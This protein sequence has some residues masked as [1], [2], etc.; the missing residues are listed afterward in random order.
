M[1]LFF[2]QSFISKQL[3]ATFQNAWGSAWGNATTPYNYI[4]TVAFFCCP[5]S[6][7]NSLPPFS[8]GMNLQICF[9]NETA[10][11]TE[12]ASH[13]G[14]RSA[15]VASGH[16]PTSPLSPDSPTSSSS[17][18]SSSGYSIASSPS[19]LQLQQ[20]HNLQQNIARP[21]VLSLPPLR[22]DSTF[23]DAPIDEADFFA[24]QA[25]LQTEARMA[26]AQAKEMAHMQMEVER[27]KLKQNPITE[28]VRES[29]S[30]VSVLFFT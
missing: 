6:H 24:R 2:I 1:R 22:L 21:Q 29:L 20:L 8:A 16:G 9:M 7:S 12:S 10:S 25:R 26:L 13:E 11:D 14:P 4:I 3:R 5:P 23:Q 19:K 30:K 17:S 15:A 27:Q 28:M 18:S